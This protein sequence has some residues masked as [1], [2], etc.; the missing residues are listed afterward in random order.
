M[1]QLGVEPAVSSSLEPCP[2]AFPGICVARAPA[3]RRLRRSRADPADIRRVLSVALGRM[4]TIALVGT[5]EA[6][7]VYT[8]GA[9]HGGRLGYL[10][11]AV[12]RQPRLV[13]ALTD[14]QCLQIAAGLDHSVF[15][16]GTHSV[17]VC[18][19]VTEPCQLEEPT[20]IAALSSFDTHVRQIGAGHGYTG[21]V[22]A[23]NMVAVWPG[24]DSEI[25]Q[26]N[27]ARH[28]PKT[29]LAARGDTR[30]VFFGY[31]S[32]AVHFADG[33]AVVVPASAPFTPVPLPVCSAADAGHD[34]SLKQ[35]A[36]GATHSALLV[37]TGSGPDFSSL[38]PVSGVEMVS[39]QLGGL[40][41]THEYADLSLSV[42]GSVQALVCHR[43]FLHTR[44]GKFRVTDFPPFVRGVS[45]ATPPGPRGSH[46]ATVQSPP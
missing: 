36:L 42:D 45:R 2:V 38:C 13:V 34:V 15:L 40:D 4:H 5:R 35:V 1:G 12:V 3:R 22:T 39:D 26:Q 28:N 24:H 31:S 19:V 23:D 37:Q 21:V 20:R 27:A 11:A 8:W 18:G 9:S 17:Y 25:T 41:A 30:E 7:L 46:D 10:G 6:P 43:V 16:S 32:F 44:L 29:A 33:S 14:K